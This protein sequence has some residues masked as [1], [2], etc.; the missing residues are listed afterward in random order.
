LLSYIERSDVEVSPSTRIEHLDVVAYGGARRARQSVEQLFRT[1]CGLLPKSLRGENDVDPRSK[2]QD[3][4]RLILEIASWA[5][6]DAWAELLVSPMDNWRE[7]GYGEPAFG[8]GLSFEGG[9][10]RS[11]GHARLTRTTASGLAIFAPRAYP[12]VRPTTMDMS[13]AAF[14]RCTSRRS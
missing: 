7:D 5:D 14:A 13:D 9:P 4:W 1:A 10:G 2:W 8:A 11:N 6:E 12:S 3:S